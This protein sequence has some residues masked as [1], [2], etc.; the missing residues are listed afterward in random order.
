MAMGF[1]VAFCICAIYKFSYILTPLKIIQSTSSV[2]IIIAF[3]LAISS[4]DLKSL[5]DLT[6][7][8]LA[9]VNLLIIPVFTY[10]VVSAV[11]N[12][13]QLI[14]SI[15]MYAAIGPTFVISSDFYKKTKTRITELGFLLSVVTM[16]I[17]NYLFF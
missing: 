3:A 16:Y 12:N 7:L 17:L 14:K 15:I 8:M 13:Q 11:T 4:I 6:S 10:V 2:V 1:S 5:L 9:V